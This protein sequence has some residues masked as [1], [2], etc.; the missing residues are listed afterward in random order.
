MRRCNRR[1]TGY[2]RQ[3]RPLYEAK[4]RIGVGTEQHP[5]CYLCAP[6]VY[7]MFHVWELFAAGGKA[8]RTQLSSQLVHSLYIPGMYKFQRHVVPK[9]GSP[10]THVVRH[11]QQPSPAIMP[12]LTLPR[13]SCYRCSSAARAEG[14]HGQVLQ[15]S[16]SCSVY[17]QGETAYTAFTL[18]ASDF[19]LRSSYPFFAPRS[20]PLYVWSAMRVGATCWADMAAAAAAAAD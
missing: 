3:K 4:R 20:F 13:D 1:R 6:Y 17:I 7:G 12:P 11:T 16:T 19:F 10:W 14:T 9:T 8:V 18:S 5:S 2:I 15:R